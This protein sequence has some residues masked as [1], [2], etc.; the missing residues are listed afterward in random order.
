[1]KKR[2]VA[3]L[4]AAA[5]ILGVIIGGTMAYMQHGAAVVNTFTAGKIGITLTETDKDGKPVEGQNYI[6]AP[7]TDLPKDP[8]VTVAE[9]SESCYLFV[10]VTEKNIEGQTT[11]ITWA[12]DDSDKENGWKKVENADGLEKGESLYYRTYERGSETR[13]F[14]V[15]KGDKVTVPEDVT[16]TQL[17]TYKDNRPE[18]AF[19]AYAIQKDWLT[20]ENGETITDDPAAIWALVKDAQPTA[21]QN[22]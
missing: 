13:E 2:T 9:G 22:A 5:A 20:G 12:I 11:P 14:S 7:G 3:V 19:K 16:K 21:T 6:M 18:L 10:K 17:A 8:K 1:M 4:C 15:L